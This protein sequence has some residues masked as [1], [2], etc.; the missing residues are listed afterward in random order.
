MLLIIKSF[1]ISDLSNLKFADDENIEGGVENLVFENLEIC[2][3]EN[4]ITDKFLLTYE[5][6]RKVFLCCQ[7]WLE[8]AKKYYS[9]E[10]L[11]SDHIKIIQD[12]SQAYSYLAFFEEDD[13]RQSKMHKKRINMIEDLLKEIN[14]TYYMQYCRQLWYELGEIYTDILNIKLD[15]VNKSDE[16]PTPHALAKINGLCDKS[17]ESYSQFL[18]SLKD[19]KTGNFPEKLDDDVIK[20][21]VNAYAVIARNN[22]KKIALDKNVQLENVTKSYEAYK[23]AVNIGEKSE[24]AL[25]IM[26]EEIGLCKEMVNILPLKISKLMSV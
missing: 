19:P 12:H 1:L 9:L 26:S 25:S 3:F 8:K 23:A 6:A 20:P 24:Y 16:R 5:D 22:M 18:T 11:A 15:K 21:V 2:T 4:I 17:I 10:N 13:D 14:P 7:D